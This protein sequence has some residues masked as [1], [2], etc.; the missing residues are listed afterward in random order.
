MA[1]HQNKPAVAESL[2]IELATGDGTNRKSQSK[3]GAEI[4][5]RAAYGKVTPDTLCTFLASYMDC[6]HK[7]KA[8]ITAGL[9]YSSILKA[10]KDDPDFA[11]EVEQAHELF[12]AK[13]SD[14]AY[15]AAVS[16]WKKPLFDAKGNHVG[17]EWKFS[18]RI[19]ELLLKRHD[20]NFR[21]KIEV[22]QKVSGGVLVVQAPALTMD[23]WKQQVA[24]ARG[25][26]RELIDSTATPILPQNSPNPSENRRE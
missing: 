21:D 5:R 26:Q 6:G 2:G 16:G 18:E 4:V 14:A 9:S 17:D 22:D 11:A 3:H 24:A 7:A 15:K 25:V 19:L 1:Q 13:L 8:A 23:Q 20:H 10:E 12:T